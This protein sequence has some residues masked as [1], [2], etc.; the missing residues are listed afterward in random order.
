[1]SSVAA[2]TGAVTILMRE[3][4]T[5]QTVLGLASSGVEAM[6]GAPQFI[7]NAQRQNTSGLSII[8][9]FI[10]LAGDLYKLSYYMGNSSPLALS[11][12]AS[13]QIFTDLCILAQFAVYRKNNKDTKQVNESVS[14]SVE[15]SKVSTSSTYASLSSINNE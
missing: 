4:R 3:N 7:L 10:W 1:M 8:L 2:A 9:I 14:K 5:Y 12:C 15:S 6:L 13:F 11:A